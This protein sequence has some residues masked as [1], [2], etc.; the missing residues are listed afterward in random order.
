LLC[1][2]KNVALKGRNVEL[3]GRDVALKG[4]YLTAALE[5]KRCSSERQKY[6]T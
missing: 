2:I 3:R 1:Y 4:A 5:H 6:R